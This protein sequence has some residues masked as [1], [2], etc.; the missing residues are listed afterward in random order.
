VSIAADVVEL[1]TR[2]A[3]VWEADHSA[4]PYFQDNDKVEKK[5]ATAFARFIVDPNEVY[6]RAGGS[7]APLMGRTG[8]VIVQLCI[9]AATGTAQ[10]WA[11]ADAV[12][13]IFHMWRSDDGLVRCSDTVISRRA[14]TSQDP[15][16]NVKLSTF[17]ESLR[18]G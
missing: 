16:F 7:D 18:H 4:I 9:P 10:A 1:Q 17:Y 6:H 3:D 14:P 2:F 13:G 11:L 5:P 12:Q 8:R 15:Y